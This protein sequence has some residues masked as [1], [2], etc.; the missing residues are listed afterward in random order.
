MLNIKEIRQDF[1]I[2]NE[3]MNGKSLIYL[4]SA[5]TSLKPISVLNALENYNARKS[6]NVHRGVYRLSQEATELYE[7]A[8][9]T[10]ARFINAKTEEIVFT[11]GATAA[12]N[13]VASGYGLSNLKQ[14][15]EIITC[16][17]EHHSSF[18]PW[19]NIA[20]LTGA[21][22]IFIP[23]DKDGKITT[24]N[25]KSVLSE[26]TKVVAIN[27][28]SN[29]MGCIAPIK[30]ICAIAHSVDAVVSID[31]SQAAPHIP[32]D[33]ID[34][35]CDFLSFT[36][37]KML[38]ATGIGVLYGKY[39]ILNKMKPVSFGGEMIDIV[40]LS[41]S[42]F[43]DAP[44]K[45]EAGTPPIAAAISLKSAIEYLNRIGFNAINE[46]EIKLR[47]YAVTGLKKLNGITIYNEK[48][49][50][51]IINFN[52]DGVHPHDIATFYDAHGICIRAGHHCAQLLMSWL[53]QVSTLRASIYLYST[54]EE[55][56]R[57]IEVTNIAKEAFENGF[58]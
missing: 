14:G 3:K 16:E 43:K 53:N 20:E 47:N 28:V 7:G 11:S 31:A 26:K 33:V 56:D 40:D 10:V 42:S 37:H 21:K 15:D 12:L 19:Q 13:L 46:H 24:D 52:V 9:E 6:S 5:A 36:G 58:F 22:L 8:R 49:D 41:G 4:D 55:I 54:E 30:E 50:I 17:L 45:F 23:L 34:L 25:F 57:F 32:I 48:S 44:Y 39:E 2:L 38:S 51:G 27:Y 1:P 29:T 18:L 35:D